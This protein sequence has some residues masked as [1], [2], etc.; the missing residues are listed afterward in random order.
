MLAYL[1]VLLLVQGSPVQFQA[2]VAAA[3]SG[4]YAPAVRITKSWPMVPHLDFQIGAAFGMVGI[5]GDNTYCDMN[6]QCFTATVRARTQEVEIPA[7]L[8][9]SSGPL[10]VIGGPVVG[11]RATCTAVVGGVKWDSCP[12]NSNVAWGVAIGGGARRALPAGTLS[13]EA[14]LQHFMTPLVQLVTGDLAD[15]FH[16]YRP[17]SVTV[18]L[19]WSRK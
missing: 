9:L 15:R 1:S 2:G 8:V 4:Q 5:D 19:G 13:I 7:Q 12:G 10:Y 11:L 16:E 18:S 17:R 6:Q 14:R 3:P